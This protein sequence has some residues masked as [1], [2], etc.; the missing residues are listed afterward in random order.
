[1]NGSECWTGLV[2]SAPIFFSHCK[3]GTLS[4]CQSARQLKQ[5]LSG[6]PQVHHNIMPRVQ[7][8]PTY[9]QIQLWSAQE[10]GLHFAQVSKQF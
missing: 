3:S 10:N 7:S 4:F 5:A 9:Q 1:M 8:P 2:H 6:L